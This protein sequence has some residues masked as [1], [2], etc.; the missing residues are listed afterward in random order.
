MIIWGWRG[1]NITGNRGTFFCPSC[2]AE[3]PYAQKT[4]R[5][6]FTLYFIPIIPLDKVG[7]LVECSQCRKQYRPE[8]LSHDPRRAAKALSDAF[9]VAVKKACIQM[10]LADGRATDEEVK[11]VRQAMADSRGVEATPAEV[12]A[13][14]DA[15]QRSP[16]SIEAYIG[17][18]AGEL[19]D[20]GKEILIRSVIEVAIA[21]AGP[22][23]QVEPQ[24]WEFLQK[25]AAA[26][27]MSP[28]HLRGIM[29][30]PTEE[31][32]T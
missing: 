13:D 7:E 9:A 25:L 3:R 28:A 5:R 32:H 14:I 2:Q 21:D 16:Q 8:V 6:F 15:E 29:T 19:N 27:K 22:D 4:V 26:L 30:P 23:G 10:A 11:A 18:V 31:E 12:Q 1:V 20:N 24:E 17:P